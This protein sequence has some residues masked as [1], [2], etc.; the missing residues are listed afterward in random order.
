VGESGA[1]EFFRRSAINGEVEQMFLGQYQHNVDSKGRLTIPVRYREMLVDGAYITQ[2]FERNLMVMT[3]SAFETITQ[4]VKQMS[5][6]D[7]RARLLRR[8]FYSSGERVDV[9]KA[10][11][12]LIPQFLRNTAGLNGEAVVAGVGDYFEI[13]SPA[14]W[15]DQATIL[16]DADSNAER[17]IAFDITSENP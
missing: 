12:I 9:D 13:W 14:A 7:P 3:V 11:R 1:P 2:G 17:F 10:G 16:E 15:A 6:T 5:I 4:R 8:L